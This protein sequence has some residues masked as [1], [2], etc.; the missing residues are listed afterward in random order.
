MGRY[1]G[2]IHMKIEY[3]GVKGNPFT[4]LNL[5]VLNFPFSY[6]VL[7]IIKPLNVYN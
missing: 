1:I 4:L 7:S 3:K 2:E 5:L 6:L